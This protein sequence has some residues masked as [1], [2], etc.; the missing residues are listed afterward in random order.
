MQMEESGNM[1]LMLAGVVQKLN[2]TDFL[3]PYWNVMEIWAQYLNSTLPDPGNQLCIDNF[4]CTFL[5]FY[6]KNK[7]N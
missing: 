7:M 3:K 5:Q 1:F 2:N 6:A 4:V